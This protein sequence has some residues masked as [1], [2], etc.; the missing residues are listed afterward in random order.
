[1]L[2]C[3]IHCIHSAS[4]TIHHSY[5]LKPEKAGNKILSIRIEQRSLDL[6]VVNLDID[7]EEVLEILKLRTLDL[8]R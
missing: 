8:V 4:L 6:R 5:L 2:K 1:L 7:Y 3:S